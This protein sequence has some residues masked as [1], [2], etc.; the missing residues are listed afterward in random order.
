MVRRHQDR[1]HDACISFFDTVVSLISFPTFL[2]LFLLA[3]LGFLVESTSD[4]K[5][6]LGVYPVFLFYFVI[7]WVIVIC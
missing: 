1:D 5:R 7:S 4:T 3:A 2:F 6:L